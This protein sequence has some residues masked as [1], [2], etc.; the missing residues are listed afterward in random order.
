VIIRA[1]KGEGGETRT[2]DG[3]ILHTEDGAY[4]PEAEAVLRDA[5]PLF[6]AD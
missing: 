5:G 4:T 2:A 3:L 6:I 1:V